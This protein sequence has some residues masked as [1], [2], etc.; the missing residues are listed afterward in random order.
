MVAYMVTPLVSK[1]YF[2]VSGC[3]NEILAFCQ[4][5]YTGSVSI[6]TVPAVTYKQQILPFRYYSH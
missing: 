3:R 6:R 5:Q 2:F 4:S 1:D